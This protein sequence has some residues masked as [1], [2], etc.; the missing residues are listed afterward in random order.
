MEG[1]SFLD[2]TGPASIASVKEKSSSM[3]EIGGS[4]QTCQ[5]GSSSKAGR[6]TRKKHSFGKRTIAPKPPTPKAPSLP[7]ENIECLEK[8]KTRNDNSGGPF[9]DPKSLYIKNLDI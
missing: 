5:R 6:N 3:P 9:L 1:I 7:E 2:D 8:D 4:P